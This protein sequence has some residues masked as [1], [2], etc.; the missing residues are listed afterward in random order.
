MQKVISINLNGHAYQLEESGYEAIRDYLATAARDLEGNPDL[1]E[2]MAD[3][4]QAI[5][6]KCQR[7][8]APHKSVVTA[9]EVRQIV[10]EMGPIDATP[11]AGTASAEDPGAKQQAGAGPKRL[12]R[13]P[14]GAMIAGVCQGLASYTGIDVTVVRVAFFLLGVFSGVGVVAYI[15]MMFVVPEASTPEERAAAGAVPFNAQD[16]VDRA[17]KQ[18][19]EGTRRMRRHW[20]RHY[21]YRWGYGMAPASAAIS[22]GPRFGGA[23]LPLF[24][25]IHLFVFLVMASLLVGLV[26]TGEILGRELPDDMPLW[27]AVLTLLVVYQIFVSPI[28]AAARWSRGP[29]PGGYAFWNTVIALTGIA[30][31]F[32]V[33]S[34]H[35]PEVR[36]FLQK[37]PDLFRDFM[38]AVRDLVNS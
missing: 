30:I 23:L 24:G 8:L 32:F 4:E 29:D 15:V 25:L 2:I 37:L 31:V 12:F 20:R 1:T 16:V 35:M 36:E 3:L 18:Y 28:R 7:F 17:K 13:I 10:A 21:R 27:A 33:A 22:A 6:D 5:A 9:A 14:D 19:A 26:N 38:H 11:G 34:N